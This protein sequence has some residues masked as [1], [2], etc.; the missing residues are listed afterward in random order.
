MASSYDLIPGDFLVHSVLSNVYRLVLH[1][2]DFCHFVV[3]DLLTQELH[4]WRLPSFDNNYELVA[5]LHENN[6]A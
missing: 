4:V 3:Q 5:R 2:V 1:R 6:V